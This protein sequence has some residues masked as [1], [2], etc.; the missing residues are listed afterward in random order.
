[1]GNSLNSNRWELSIIAEII[2]NF[3]EFLPDIDLAFNLNDEYRVLLLYY[4]LK[5]TL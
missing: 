1:M 4:D 2:N 3:A 5:N